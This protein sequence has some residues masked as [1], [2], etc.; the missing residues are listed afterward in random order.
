MNFSLIFYAIVRDAH[1]EIL[2][3]QNTNEYEFT[4]PVKFIVI[5]RGVI[6]SKWALHPNTKKKHKICCLRK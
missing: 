6:E 5:E 4:Y 3:A 1:M 2:E